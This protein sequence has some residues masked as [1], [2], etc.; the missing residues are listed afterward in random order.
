MAFSCHKTLPLS[1]GAKT[2]QFDINFLENAFQPGRSI[3]IVTDTPLGTTTS[4][5]AQLIYFE[6]ER[7]PYLDY[8][9][10]E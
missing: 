7:I 5:P 2:T 10:E 8:W 3:R 1:I 9:P 6:K 4:I